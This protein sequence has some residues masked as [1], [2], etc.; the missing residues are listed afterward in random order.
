MSSSD[1]PTKTREIGKL[2]RVQQSVTRMIKCS[3]HLLYK[4]RLREIELCSLERR[5]LRTILLMCKNT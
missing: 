2:E 4:P 1:L 3:Q 5:N